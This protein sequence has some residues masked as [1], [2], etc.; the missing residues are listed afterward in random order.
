MDLKILTSKLVKELP[1]W[2]TVSPLA[3][4]ELQLNEICDLF[5]LEN[6]TR[7][8][9]R[10]WALADYYQTFGEDLIPGDILMRD[11]KAEIDARV[12]YLCERAKNGE[13]TPEFLS[14]V[15]SSGAS[16]TA[17]ILMLFLRCKGILPAFSTPDL[18]FRYNENGVPDVGL[19]EGL[20]RNFTEDSQSAD[21]RIIP[22][23]SGLDSTTQQTAAVPMNDLMPALMVAAVFDHHEIEM[24]KHPAELQNNDRRFVSHAETVHRMSFEEAEVLSDFRD[25]FPAADSIAFAHEHGIRIDMLHPEAPDK[26][27]VTIEAGSS[28][29]KQKATI[30]A[31]HDEVLIAK[32]NTGQNMRPVAALAELSLQLMG[33]NMQPDVLSVADHNISMV[34]KHTP[35]TQLFCSEYALE[36]DMEIAVQHS[37]ICVIGHDLVR[38]TGMAG[39]ITSALSGF[40][41]EMIVMGASDHAMHFVVHRK[42]LT[43]ALNQIQF[44]FFGLKA[45]S[46][47]LLN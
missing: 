42:Y 1:E 7:A 26:T 28:K 8:E 13:V 33:A 9:A 47:T 3:G 6:I 22:A 43:Q 23:T 27:I 35:A 46:A 39:K 36:H 32:I 24:W 18:F 40:P 30:C 19:S 34:L 14:E 17:K 21:V 44:H 31:I 5:Q 45:P 16:W 38:T 10:F 2:I 41:M 12:H 37:V 4:V 20:L 25:D 15:R 29:K 11:L